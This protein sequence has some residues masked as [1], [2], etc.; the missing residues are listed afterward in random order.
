MIKAHKAK[1]KA[2]ALIA[3]IKSQKGDL[4]SEEQINKLPAAQRKRVNTTYKAE[5]AR[6]QRVKKAEEKRKRQL[7]VF[8]TLKK[9]IDNGTVLKD[10]DI[11]DADVNAN[12]RKQLRSL[13][14]ALKKKKAIEAKKAAEAAARRKKLEAD[15]L[16][17]LNAISSEI[18]KGKYDNDS[19]AFT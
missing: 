16:K 12:Q 3:K 4:P 2:D 11:D 14:A 5:K 17:L 1:V 15:R 18:A 13:N 8:T 9:K 7:R 10:E 19:K 6:R